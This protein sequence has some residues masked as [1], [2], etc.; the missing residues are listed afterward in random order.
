MDNVALDSH[1]RYS[2]GSIE[3]AEGRILA[4]RS[5]P[6]RRGEIRDFLTGLEPGTPVAVET[7]GSW[8]CIVDEIDFAAVCAALDEIG[9][10]GLAA[11][12]LPR[13]DHDPVTT[14]ARAI[15]YFRELGTVA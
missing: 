13:H 14:A 8:Y 7:I 6:H 2:L 1:K 10:S 5:I 15:A 11:V 9:F 4:E 12:E 3:N